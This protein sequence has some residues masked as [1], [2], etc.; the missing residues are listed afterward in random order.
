MYTN[1][2]N[3]SV[4]KEKRFYNMSNPYAKDKYKK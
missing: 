2:G 4:K 3:E 1:S